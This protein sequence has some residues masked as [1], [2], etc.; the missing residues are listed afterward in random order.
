MNEFRELVDSAVVELEKNIHDLESTGIDDEGKLRA[1]LELLKKKREALE[2][3]C[4]RSA[5]AIQ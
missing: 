2:D 3:V 5:E 4:R 1:R